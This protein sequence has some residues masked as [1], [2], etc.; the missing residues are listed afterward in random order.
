[1][2]PSRSTGANTGVFGLWL[3][4]YMKVLPG[5]Q[6]LLV[7]YDHGDPKEYSNVAAI[8]GIRGEKVSYMN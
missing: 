6:D 1:M 2:I 5:Y 7:Y 8:K 3:T 4:Q